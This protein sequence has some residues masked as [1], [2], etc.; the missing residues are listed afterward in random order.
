MIKFL[1]AAAPYLLNARQGSS[2]KQIARS[3]TALVLFAL[4]G[5][6]LVA[7][8]FIYVMS[9]YGAAL[10]F[11][12]ISVMFMAVGLILFLKTKKSGTSGRE[13]L[14][15]TP[16]SDPVAGLVPDAIMKDPAVSKLLGQ[17]TANPIAASVAAAAIAMLITREI[18]K[19]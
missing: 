17:V 13:K 9:V 2:Q 15:D 16:T 19:D 5:F 12:C 6:A 18:M 7:A 3:I 4:S 10:A 8:V 14:S 11:V 1:L